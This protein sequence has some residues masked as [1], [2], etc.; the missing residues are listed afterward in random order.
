[1]LV[2]LLVSASASARPPHSIVFTAERANVAAGERLTL[3]AVGFRTPAAVRVYLVRTEWKPNIRNA[4]DERLWFV[5][6]V[7]PQGRSATVTFT[8]PPIPS[9]SYTLW[10]A[11][12]GRYRSPTVT[13]TMPPATRTSCPI[14]RSLGR[15]G[16]DL[17]WTELH[18]GVLARKP[19]ADGSISYKFG[20][21]P[22]RRI[23]GELSVSG[24]RLDGVSPPMRVLGVNWGY[25]STG[26]ASWATA[27]VFPEP[28]CWKLTARM[29]AAGRGFAVN[30]AY[31]LKV[32]PA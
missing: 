28:G 13:V 16:H 8:V 7:R 25:S 1:M 29:V 31:V 30:L 24:R 3:R 5:G 22:S 4:L 15:Y 19:D 32:E 11:N 14:T 21:I 2:A 17:L 9:G 23:A 18:G 27:V 10:C 12:C 20:W 26:R 6:T